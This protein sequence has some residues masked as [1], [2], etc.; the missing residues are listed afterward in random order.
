MF[1]RP[2]AALASFVLL[3][4]LLVFSFLLNL[5]DTPLHLWDESRRAVDA[6]DMYLN[7][8][9]IIN[10]YDG[11]EGDWST[12][13]PILLWLQVLSIKLFGINEFAVRLPSA[14]AA[15]LI[16][17]CIWQF[18]RIHLK[19]AWI[20]FLAGSVFSLTYAWVFNHAGRTADYDAFLTLFSVCYCFCFFLYCIHKKDN[21]LQLFFL[22]LTLAVLLKGVA[23]LFFLPGLA[24][25]ALHENSLKRLS[26]N[27]WTYF[28]MLFLIIV[29]GGYYALRE[30]YAPGFLKAVSNNEL[31]GRYLN[32]LEGNSLPFLYY[33]KN[34]QWRYP[35][36]VYFVIPAFAITFFA[37][38]PAIKK[39]TVFNLFAV[40]SFWLII[41]FSK[42]KLD[43]YDLPVYPFLAVQISLLFHLLLRLLNPLLERCNRTAKFSLVI[44]LYLALIAFPLALV[45]THNFNPKKTW[46]WDAESDTRMQGYFLKDALKNNDPLNGYVFCYDG[47]N[48]HLRFYVKQLQLGKST[49]RLCTNIDSLQ[50][51]DCVVV[52]QDELRQ[53]L[54]QR[55]QLEKLNEQFGCSV[56]LIR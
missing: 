45:H 5:G 41:S 39:L 3:C 12:K 49:V 9:W 51:G 25:F 46:P 6:L 8:K 36:W 33:T 54:Q 55:Y 50:A 27:K 14:L 32:G 28:G 26:T 19:D 18:C 48:S 35:Y 15:C 40:S 43:W 17:I 10:F 30:Y 21:W 29:V 34:L 56:Y 53:K 11:V 37:A 44:A 4:M 16:G 1:F 2:T 52:S 47:H 22:F 24:L 31:G 38:S 13:S 7:H 23:G 42:T 20:G